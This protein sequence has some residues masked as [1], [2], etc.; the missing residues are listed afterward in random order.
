MTHVA[1]YNKNEK[2]IKIMRF[3]KLGT[4]RIFFF[5]LTEDGKRLNSTLFARKYDAVSLGKQYLNN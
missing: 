5:P 3:V 4:N 2:S 1:T